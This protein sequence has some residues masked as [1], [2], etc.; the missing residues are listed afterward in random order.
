M[1]LQPHQPGSGACWSPG[2]VALAAAEA[3]ALRPAT[4]A[5]YEDV[6]SPE[7]TAVLS[8]TPGRSIASLLPPDL[9]GQA[10]VC[11]YQG[12]YI[13]RA[14]W[15][16]PILPGDRVEFFA[17]PQGGGN[18]SVRQILSLALIVAALAVGQAWAPELIL[19]GFTAS[20]T[21]TQVAA[22]ISTAVIIG[23]NLALNAL[24]PIAQPQ[25][26]NAG[27]A[28][29]PSYNVALS[30]NSARLEGAIPVLYG[31]NRTFPDFSA[32]PYVSFDNDTSDQY[33]HAILC[34]GHGSY[35]VGGIEIDDTPISTYADVETVVLEPGD[36]PTIVEPAVATAAEVTGQELMPG[37]YVGAFA[38]NKPRTTATHLEFDI[39]LQGLG[40]LNNDGSISPLTVQV[41]FE[42]R[43]INDWGDA[44]GAPWI[45][46]GTQDITAATVD[47]VR[48]SYRYALTTP[49]RYLVRAVRTTAKDTSTS[50]AN[51]P[52]WVGCKAVLS[53][54]APDN[55]TT[56]I[57]IRMRAS[58]QLNGFTQRKIAVRSLRRLLTWSPGSGWSAEPVETRNPA[59]A[60]ADKWRSTVYG[61]GIAD[62][63]I[64]LPSLHALA[65]L[66]DERQDR[67]DVVFDTFT[68]SASADQLIANTGRAKVIE[69]NGR[70][71]VVR[72]GPEP[73]PVTMYSPRMMR[74]GSW[75]T[76]YGLATSDS[77]DGLI[78]EYW[79][80]RIWDWA[81]MEIP[82]PG[83]SATDPA[84]PLYDAE[85]PAMSRPV[86]QRVLGII[87]Q[88]QVRRE[89]LYMAAKLLYRRNIHA[90]QTEL[91]GMLPSYGR[92]VYLA[93]ALPTWG[94]SGD[95]V[96]WDGGTLTL[97]LSEPVAF[98][99]GADHYVIL[100][101]DDG[102]VAG[103]Y[104]ATAVDGDPLAV[105]LEEAPDFELICDSADRERPRFTF[106]AGSGSEPKLAK[107]LAIRPSGM[108]GQGAPQIEMMA[109]V[110]DDRVHDADAAWLPE[111]E[112]V[113][114]PV[115]LEAVASEPGGGGGDGGGSTL[116][117]TALTSREIAARFIG[118]VTASFT[119]A[120]DGRAKQFATPAGESYIGSEWLLIAPT[121][122]VDTA[123]FEARATLSSGDTPTSGAVG[124]WQVLSTSRTWELS[125]ST[126][127]T[128]L[129][130]VLD[131]E[132]RDAATETVQSS[133]TVTL[134]ATVDA[135]PGGGGD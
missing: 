8:V 54:T 110:D 117:L 92:S 38:A 127:G 65:Q 5:V 83:R 105:Q 86:R 122:I 88:H 48:R 58:E 84:D 124:T 57:E 13:L 66:W 19:S 41:R 85:L 130:S 79:D 46:L 91:Q 22:V 90:W 134:R 29:S 103:P 107:V 53:G 69:R 133:C 60:L 32:P 55:S 116:L 118:G 35:T 67:C 37:R 3:C 119:L 131:I 115:H 97:S 73:V 64:D 25:A 111:G 49:G 9:A 72:D 40:K 6:M 120:A 61:D 17:V 34:I 2:A 135:S 128:E 42:A 78:L 24:L 114:D 104:P 93:P 45:V 31:F 50:A 101:R 70:L 56:R 33:Y 30:G 89:G 14:D 4:V 121:S 28:A 95:V 43:P 96:A 102:S 108:D 39:A 98:A 63:D 15:V 44:E 7:P 100:Q 10:V 18:G 36:D 77:P 52:H 51:E 1:M 112:E 62:D 75:S 76:S 126:E 21:G 94:I 12:V 71:T 80:H 26:P 129:V 11:R 109:V 99:D 47:A 125:N 82:A 123:L 59:W 23:G 20:L 74:P 106:G 68:D 113:Q 87:G 16:R 27:P 132:I 81:E